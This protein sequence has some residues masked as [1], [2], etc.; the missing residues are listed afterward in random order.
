ME[1]KGYGAQQ[2]IQEILAKN[3]KQRKIENLLRKL[4]ETAV[5]CSMQLRAV[6]D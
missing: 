4:Q 3:W 1:I 2:L 5:W 6:A